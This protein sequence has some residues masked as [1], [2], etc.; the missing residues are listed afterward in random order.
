[1]QPA[2]MDLERLGE[3]LLALPNKTRP[4]ASGRTLGGSCPIRVA[5][6]SRART[7]GGPGG[8]W[9]KTYPSPCRTTHGAH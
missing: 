9:S 4:A 3:E 2:A 7:P 8:P 6:F 5:G 1:M